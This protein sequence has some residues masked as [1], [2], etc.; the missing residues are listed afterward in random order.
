MS[1]KL[2][3]RRR[4]IGMN[5]A[6]VLDSVIQAGSRGVT[7]RELSSHFPGSK[8]AAEFW[9]PLFDLLQEKKV[10][11]EWSTCP[12]WRTHSAV[13]EGRYFAL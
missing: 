12:D 4:V 3:I 5:R 1:G 13:Q 2:F 7:A 9:R 11:Q 8:D 10:R 6:H